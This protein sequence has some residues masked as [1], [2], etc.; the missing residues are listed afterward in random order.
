VWSCERRPNGAK[1]RPARAYQPVDFGRHMS[2]YS[3]DPK[4]SRNDF[5][6]PRTCARGPST[7]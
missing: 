6:G 1:K 2:Q 3:R 4:R 5:S 7:L